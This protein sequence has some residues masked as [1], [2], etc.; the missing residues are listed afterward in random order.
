MRR[1]AWLIFYLCLSLTAQAADKV[2]TWTN[3]Q[4]RTMQAEFLREVDGD[5]TFLKDGKLITIPLEQLS[6]DD[7]KVIRELEAAKAVDDRRR[8]DPAASNR[9]P[10]LQP[11]APS[12]TDDR[13]LVPAK[14]KVV[15]TDRVWTTTQGNQTTARFVRVLGQNVVLMRGTRTV[16][17]PFDSLTSADQDYVREVLISRGEEA[18]LPPINGATQQPPDPAVPP[19]APVPAADPPQANAGAAPQPPDPDDGTTLGRGNSSFFDKL[20]E[21]DQQTR[22]QHAQHAAETRPATD[23]VSQLAVTQPQAPESGIATPPADAPASGPP[24]ETRRGSRLHTTLDPQQAKDVWG[25]TVIVVVVVGVIGTVGLIVFI[26]ISIASA[27]S[28][29]QRRYSS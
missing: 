5:A 8:D 3:V 2:R 17:L 26:A 10:G 18:L 23:G 22:E 21:R 29:R 14:K 1:V 28:S 4:G 15:V 27:S 20:R 16:T 11:V 24:A 12:R 9:R 25:A 19:A 7:R 13:L 6:D